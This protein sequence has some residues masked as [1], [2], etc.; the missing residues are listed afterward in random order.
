[1]NEIETTQP[2][3]QQAASPARAGRAEW[4]GLAALVLPSLLVAIDGTALYYALPFISADLEPTSDQMLW[5]MDSYGFVLAGLLVTM[6][7]LG[8]RIGRRRLLLVGAAAF[9][10][11]SVIAAWAPSAEA[12]IAARALLGVGGATLAPSTL[13]LIRNMFHDQ[14]QRRTAIGISAGAFSGGAVLGPIVGG[15]LLEHF[16]WGSVFLLNVPV[17]LLLLVVGP[18]L[19]PEHRD[20]NPGRFDLLSALMSL[21]AVLPVVY[22]IKSVAVHG[23]GTEP[24][25]AI[26]AGLV[27]GTA[28][29]RRQLRRP[30]PMIDLAL[31][32]NPAFVGAIVTVTATM[33]TVLGVSL[34]T[35]QYIQLVL[36]YGPL[37]SALWSLPPF[38]AMPIGITLATL[39]VRRA[40]VAHVVGAGLLLVSLG[41]LG[42]STVDAD[43][44]VRLLLA[45]SVMTIGIGMVTTIATELVVGVAPP[46]RAGAAAAMSETA[47]E[48]GGSLGIA[49]LGAVGAASYRGA[50]AD[51]TP[52]GIP[53]A[54]ADAARQTLGA[55]ES[56]ARSLPGGAARALTRVAEN[57][58]V[59]GLHVT[60]L[61]AA[62]VIAATAVLVTVLLR[63]VPAD[64]VAGEEPADEP[65]AEPA[66]EP[67]AA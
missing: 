40:R 61:S 49:V 48:L 14:R 32:R 29:V 34:F 30:D 13:A 33:F 26:A 11:A 21:G 8:D 25:V 41:V 35:S 67:V 38:L 6:G 28:F 36:G 52:A 43:G 56:V 42:I 4:L 37:E 57:A 17:M 16:W 55:A 53:D 12:L 45:A 58:F 20:P 2:D 50:M 59:S 64:A 18:L 24:A 51:T 7:V 22:G 1:M 9:G 19:L 39:G 63:D 66:D 10:A 23:W 46:E 60:A 31:F 47:N 62:A 15:L 65:V 54:V 44:L 27:V 5:I 3:G